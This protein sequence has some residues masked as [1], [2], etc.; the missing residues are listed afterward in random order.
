MLEAAENTLPFG[1]TDEKSGR[2]A[3]VIAKRETDTKRQAAEMNAAL[4]THIRANLPD[5][6][7]P[8][9]KAAQHH[10]SNPGKMLRSHVALAAAMQQ[11]MLP[12][13]AL[14]WAVALEFLHNASLVHDDIC[15][16]DHERRNRPS[17]WAAFGRPMAIC[18]GDWLIAK[19]FELSAR[20]Q[21]ATDAPF[22]ALLAHTMHELAGGQAAEFTGGQ[23]PDCESYRAIVAGKTTPLFMAAIEG[24]FFVSE[25]ISTT[26]MTACRNVFEHIGFAYQIANDIDNHN[27][28]KAGADTGDL[29]RGAPNAVYI[30]Y[31]ALL[32]E[33][34]RIAFD[35]WQQSDNKHYTTKW[36]LDIAASDAEKHAC[37]LFAEHLAAIKLHQAKLS[38]DLAELIAPIGD[39]LA[40]TK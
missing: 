14:D 31:R 21:A 3:G 40:G 11:G 22:T 1:K 35:N 24:A 30:S 2:R 33:E 27:A 29:L 15:D 16:D 38:P 5:K 10:F 6:S 17:L 36:L 39:Y 12:N 23:L 26:H 4:S 8:L 19:S 9:A 18:F 13:A 7:H 28:L 34:K 37:A 32:T 20:A 25:A